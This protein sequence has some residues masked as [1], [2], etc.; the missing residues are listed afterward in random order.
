MFM[1]ETV[2]IF[3]SKTFHSLIVLSLVDSRNS[4]LLLG[5]HHRILLIFSSISSD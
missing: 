3:L 1:H 5:L 4:A 2:L